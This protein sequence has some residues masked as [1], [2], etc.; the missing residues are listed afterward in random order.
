MNDFVRPSSRDAIITAGFAV[1]AADP[2]ASLND[3]ARKAGVGRATLHRH[4]SGRDDLVRCLALAALHEMD[5]AVEAALENAQSHT[6]A[7]KLTLQTLVPLGTQYG[8]LLSE[9][10]TGKEIEAEYQRQAEA[11]S[12]MLKAAVSEGGLSA[13]IPVSWYARSFDALLIAAWEAVQEQELTP[14]QASALAWKTFTLN[15]KADA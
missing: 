2:A 11:L 4:F 13:A 6:D 7:L 1:L 5:A 3:I 14:D 12:D 15:P 10:A 9:T 8:F